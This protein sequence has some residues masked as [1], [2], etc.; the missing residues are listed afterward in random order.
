MILHCNGTQVNCKDP[1][2]M[3]ILNVTPDSF[4]DGGKFTNKAAI[5]DQVQAMLN[6][7][8]TYIDVGGYSSR[9][10]ADHVSEEEEIKRVIPII[11][12]LSTKFP[13]IL[14]SV[15]TFRSRVA[16]SAVESGA[17]LVN[18]I[19]AGAL[20]KYMMQQV[21][22]L[23]VPY[24]M[25]HMQGTPQTMQR[26]PNYKNVILEMKEFFTKKIETAHSL[27]IKEL[28]IDPGFGFGKSMEH[29]YQILRELSQLKTFDI[30]LLVG[31][32]RKSMIYKLLET[33]PEGALNGTTALHSIALMKGANILRVHDVKEANETLRLIKK[34]GAS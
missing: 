24:I 6:Q 25:M 9:P 16:K 17:C 34:L 33:T 11:E 32:S 19:S 23:K 2:I 28:V 31:V 18:D 1:K 13:E 10:G 14:I 26:H 3:G 20:D 7:G 5:V 22:E 30:P 8:A 27:G 21:A 29:N 4:Y 12:L 15:D